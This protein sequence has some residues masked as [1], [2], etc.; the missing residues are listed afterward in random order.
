MLN[1]KSQVIKYKFF[2]PVI[3]SL[4][5]FSENYGKIYY[6]RKN[7]IDPILGVNDKWENTCTKGIESVCGRV[8]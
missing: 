4:L 7:C 8:F 3:I 1:N 5:K 6:N 2:L